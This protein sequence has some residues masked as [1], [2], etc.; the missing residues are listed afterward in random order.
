[1]YQII[2]APQ[3]ILSY[4]TTNSCYDTIS[5]AWIVGVAWHS[6]P[7][8]SSNHWEDLHS[9]GP[10]ISVNLIK[11]TEFS[12]ILTFKWGPGCEHTTLERKVG[13]NKSPQEKVSA[14]YECMKNKDIKSAYGNPGDY[15]PFSHCKLDLN[16]AGRWTAI[17]ICT[18]AI[19]ILYTFTICTH[20]LLAFMSP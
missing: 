16:S 12:P 8:T 1:M 4:A 5:V 17:T 2:L 19:H 10:N 9:G 13:Q 7:S 15:C 11:V 3:L 6:K 14:D 20:F 18:F